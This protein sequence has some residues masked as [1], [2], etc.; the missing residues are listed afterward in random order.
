MYRGK[1]KEPKRSGGSARKPEFVMINNIYEDLSCLIENYGITKVIQHLGYIANEKI[2]REF[3][4][5]IWYIVS[6]PEE[7]ELNK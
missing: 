7:R 2:S 1:R 6:K 3:A 5:K 4:S